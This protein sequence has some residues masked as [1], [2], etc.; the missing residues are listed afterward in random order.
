MMYFS[1]SLIA[2]DIGYLFLFCIFSDS[3]EV[4]VVLQCCNIDEYDSS[5][6]DKT[7]TDSFCF[8]DRY[9]C[10][11]DTGAY[12]QSVSMKTDGCGYNVNVC[13]PK[14]CDAKGDLVKS[15]IPDKCS[16]LVP[17]AVVDFPQ[18]GFNTDRVSFI[19]HGPYTPGK[20]QLR[21]YYCVFN[22]V[23]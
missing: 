14:L 15:M 18:D 10:A 23:V 16:Q 2:L 19:H 17:T 8:D 7:A 6:V 4:N 5:L 22:Q 12:L 13:F 1:R 11:T 3:V 21:F 9:E 20:L